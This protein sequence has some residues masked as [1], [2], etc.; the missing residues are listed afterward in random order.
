MPY[1]HLVGTQKAYTITLNLSVENDFNARQIDFAKVFELNEY[2][3]C[4]VYIE[5]VD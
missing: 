5:E 2:E 4:D 1:A 3:H